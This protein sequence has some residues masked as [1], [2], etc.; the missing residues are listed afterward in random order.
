MH[1]G[2]L[3]IDKPNQKRKWI[4]TQTWEHLLF[5]NWP[6]P[7]DA[8]RR[9]I[10]EE[11]EV[12]TYDGQAWI[13]VIPFLMSGIRLRV[14]PVIP[15]TSTFTEINVR[16]YVK[17]KTQ[18]GVFFLT[19]DASNPLVTRI[20]KA[21]YR[22]PYYHAKMSF[23]QQREQIEFRSSRMGFVPADFYGRYRPVDK[24][25]HPREGTIEHWLTERY[26]HYCKC[27][28]TS[29]VFHGEVFHQPWKLQEAKAEI[30]INTMTQNLNITL[31]NQPTLVYYSRGVEALIW[32]SKRLT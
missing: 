18:A 6:V 31:S 20:A 22:L 30:D 11:L 14:C 1:E 4:M 26:I 19:L 13:S 5:A 2:V 23:Q 24:C 10:P 27:A 17:S 29:Q 3:R 8:I 12:D 32:P 9:L 28:A 21:W 7:A 15:Y 16:T 25:F